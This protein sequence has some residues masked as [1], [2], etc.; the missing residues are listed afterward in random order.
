[1][2]VCTESLHIHVFIFLSF[3]TK[4]IKIVIL[5]AIFTLDKAVIP[6]SHKIFVLE[7]VKSD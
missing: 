2:A 5:M 6:T 7:L 1:M 3:L 4:V